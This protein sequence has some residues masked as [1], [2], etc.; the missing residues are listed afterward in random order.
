MKRQPT[1]TLKELTIMKDS[2]PTIINPKLAHT[3]FIVIL[4]LL[5]LVLAGTP[6]KVRAEAATLYFSPSSGSFFVGSTFDVSVFLNTE[7]NSINAVQIDVKFPPELLQVVTPTTGKS[8]IT[9]WAD[10]PFFSNKDGLISLKGGVLSPGINTSAGLAS[11]IT[12][13]VKAPGVAKISFL[14]SSK[15]LLADGQGTNILKISV[16]AEYNLIIPPPEGPIVISPTHPSLTTWY[17]N[18]N[19]AFSWEKEEGVNAYSYML[20]QDPLNIPDTTSEG[21]HTLVTFYDVEDGVWYFHIRAKKKGIW[22]KST[23]YPIRI[24]TSLPQNLKV[25]IEIMSRLTG[26]RYLAYFSAEDLLSQ[27]DHYEV[28]TIDVTDPQES[29]NPFFIESVSPYKITY[30]SSGKYTLLVRAYDK[31]GNYSQEELIFSIV[32]PLISYSDTGIQLGPLFLNWWLIYTIIGLTIILIGLGIFLTFQRGNLRKR[33]KKE[34][35]EAEKEIKDV[36]KL[37]ERIKQMRILEEETKR[38]EER[39]IRELRGTEEEK[40]P[41]PPEIEVSREGF[42]KE[43]E[44]KLK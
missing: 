9:V 18:S 13:R 28:S 7:G 6:Q 44:E 30:E 26:S 10:Q 29:V 39:L 14:S 11:T 40:E 5:F 35:A 20:D 33:L 2:L 22:G 34:I 4:G 27:I 24:D 38:E 36:K 41:E 15:V 1:T 3:K 32:S 37:E 17:R 43:L 21:N 12:F 16:P 8:F 25:H 19:P 31:A 42:K 23:H